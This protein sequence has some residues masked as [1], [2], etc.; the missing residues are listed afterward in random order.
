LAISANET[1][2]VSVDRA[3]PPVASRKSR[4]GVGDWVRLVVL[5]VG[6]IAMILPLIWMLGIALKS[7]GEVFSV[8]PTWIP[9]EFVWSNFIKGTVQIHF[10]RVFLNSTIIAVICTIGSVTSSTIVGYGLSRIK[11]V[12]RKVWFYLFI[13]SMM[14]PQ[15]VTMLPVFHLFSVLHMYNTWWPLILPSFFGNPFFIFLARQ[16]FLGISK[17]FDEAAKIDGA[18]HLQILLRVIAPMSK[19]MLVTMVIMAFQASWNDY[20]N[21][22]LYLMNPKLWTLSVAMASYIGQFGTSWNLFMAADLIYMLPVL[23][24]F[25]AAQKYFMQ[26]LGALNSS[27]LK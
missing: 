3:T 7:N 26:G 21:P 1:S 10:W 9:H 6:S 16:Y 18:S 22:L 14:L 25:F 13:G 27:G 8:P 5:V 15:M 24:I 4:Y 11:F 2:A 19:P 12:G 23:I 20:L 17:S